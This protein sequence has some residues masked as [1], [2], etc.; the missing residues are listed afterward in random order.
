MDDSV[1]RS[2]QNASLKRLRA[3][4]AGKHDG[5]IVLEGL[6]LVRDA[7][8]S[9]LELEELFVAEDREEWCEEFASL[10]DRLRV[11]DPDVLASASE[12]VTSPGLIAACREPRQYSIA[13]LEVEERA[14]FLV[15]GGIADPG[16]LGALAR[17]A[18]ALGARAIIVLR[19]GASPWNDK[20]LRGSMGSLLRLPVLRAGD[21]ESVARELAGRGVRQIVAATRGGL[22]LDEL[23]W[24]G[25]VALW[26]GGEVG[27]APEAAAD[28]E[29][30]TIPMANGAE[31]LNVTVAASLLL[32]ATG[33]VG[34]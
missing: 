19:G 5:L 14:L 33:R 18:E 11:V 34:R 22:P 28:F 26:I 29:R 1:I 16:N 4:R 25:P 23:D 15:V 9:G 3:V 7:V 8:A 21:A 27:G 17:S 31:S 12:L 30:V 20:A 2:R 10:G 32:F 13:E 24:K 6:R